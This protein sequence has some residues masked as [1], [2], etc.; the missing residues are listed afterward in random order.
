MSRT[1]SSG[2]FVLFQSKL[3]YLVIFFNTKSNDFDITILETKKLVALFKCIYYPV[4]DL[5]DIAI[6]IN[7][8][9]RNFLP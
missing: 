4:S 2:D 6:N 8:I 5:F 9:L 7:L 3:L 1:F